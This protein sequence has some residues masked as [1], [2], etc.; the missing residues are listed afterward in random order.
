[1]YKFAPTK[2]KFSMKKFNRFTQ[3]EEY[4]ISIMLKQTYL[5]NIIKHI[6]KNKFAQKRSASRLKAGAKSLRIALSQT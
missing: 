6:D 2:K 1:M 3:N 4:H 5:D